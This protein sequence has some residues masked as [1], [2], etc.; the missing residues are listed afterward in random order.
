M[1]PVLPE[2]QQASEVA[3][4]PMLRGECLLRVPLPLGEDEDGSSGLP[5]SRGRTPRV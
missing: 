1:G 2:P 3:E 5:P 4:E